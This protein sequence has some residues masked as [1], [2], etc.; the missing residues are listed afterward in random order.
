MQ[1]G[2]VQSSGLQSEAD[3]ARHGRLRWFGH[4]EHRSAD[5]WCRPVEKWRW[6][7]RDVRGGIGKL[8]RNVW[9]MTWKCLV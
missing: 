4:L 8:E 5:D 6:Q 2:F 7:G 3:V 1:C 9:I